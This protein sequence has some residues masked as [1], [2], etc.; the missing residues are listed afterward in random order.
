MSDSVQIIISEVERYK[1]A[2]GRKTISIDKLQNYLND[3][4]LEEI[5][6]SEKSSDEVSEADKLDY[7]GKLLHYRACQ[8]FS[9]ARYNAE[10]ANGLELFRAVIS[11][12]DIA[13]KTTFW[14]NGGA[15][16]AVLAFL[17]NIWN[18][19]PQPM[20]FIGF[21]QTL[22]L[23]AI[24][25]ALSSCCAGLSYITQRFYC[26]PPSKKRK[27]KKK[28]CDEKSSLLADE[29][30]YRYA[31]IACGLA[32]VFG[33]ASIGFFIYGSWTACLSFLVSCVS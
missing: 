17:G 27:T 26:N 12:A 19:Q 16:I 18:K 6:L 1:N 3:I 21:T 32:I 2:T 13:L 10:L 24:G 31:N 22:L 28:D 15:A 8:D 29:D 7:E 9:L 23:F 20:M 25:V 30:D 4:L 11:F 33:I 5:D 14:L